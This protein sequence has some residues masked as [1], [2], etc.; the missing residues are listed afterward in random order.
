[1]YVCDELH[2]RIVSEKLRN[3]SLTVRGGKLVWTVFIIPTMGF[4]WRAFLANP[5]GLCAFMKRNGAMLRG[6]GRTEKN[7]RGMGENR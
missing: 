1:M 2:F 3:S 5:R 7:R 6:T 4:I